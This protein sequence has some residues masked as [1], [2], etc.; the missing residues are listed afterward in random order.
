MTDKYTQEDYKRIKKAIHLA[1]LEQR[2]RLY[3]Q[4]KRA[5]KEKLGE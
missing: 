2:K 4:A 5:R 1:R 3:E